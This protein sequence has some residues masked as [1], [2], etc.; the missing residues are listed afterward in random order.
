MGK[1]HVVC[2]FDSTLVTS[3]VGGEMFRD[4]APADRVAK[5]RERFT[6]NE[7]SLREYQEQVF[8]LVSQSVCE[9]SQRAETS[10]SI[11]PLAKELFT[12]VWDA[13]G[14]V[15]VASAGLSFYIEPVLKKAGLEKVELASGKIV[16]GTAEL[17]PFRYDYPSA[18]T[19]CNGDWVTCKC[20]VIRRRKQ[21]DEQTE[22]IFIGDGLL[23]DACA[24]RNEADTVFATGRLLDYCVENDIE[25]TR[26]GEDF[27]PVLRYVM[28]KTSENGDQ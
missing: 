8:D 28:N 3:F 15:T 13:G 1:I 7:I 16:S 20:E 27:G 2:D 18:E 23:S 5:I 4:Y 24:A 9:M 25:V 11:R 6:S 22:V 19:S 14:T 17:P 10:A 12:E 21:G 26:F